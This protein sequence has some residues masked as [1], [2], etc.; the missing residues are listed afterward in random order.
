MEVMLCFNI[1]LDSELTHGK[2]VNIVQNKNL[3]PGF[4]V[5]FVKE[6]HKD[7]EDLS[8]NLLEESTVLEYG[9]PT[10]DFKRMNDPNIK[11]DIADPDSICW[12]KFGIV[13]LK[14][15]IKHMT[16]TDLYGSFTSAQKPANPYNYNITFTLEELESLD[17][18]L[19][20]II[21]SMGSECR[22]DYDLILKLQRET[23][24]NVE[25]LK[26]GYNELLAL[27]KNLDVN[28]QKMFRYALYSM[29]YAGM[30][31]RRW[32]GPQYPYPIYEKLTYARD[33]N[34]KKIDPEPKTIDE[35]AKVLTYMEEHEGEDIIKSLPVYNYTETMTSEFKHKMNT[36]VR[37]VL[38]GE[39]CIRMASTILIGTAVYA[40]YILFSEEPIPLKTKVDHIY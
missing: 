33:E 4:H 23:R 19:E 26:H 39:Y 12:E 15:D 24:T 40:I 1:Y 6:H 36:F 34:N 21:R 8:C 3:K 38:K 7:D 20:F 5:P 35:L 31:A 14:C 10:P 2:V 27:Y 13:N 32:K 18:T 30:Y 11:N 22:E 16:V 17:E 9:V 28:K 29:F 25:L 37:R